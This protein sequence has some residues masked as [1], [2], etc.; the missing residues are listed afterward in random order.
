M[1]ILKCIT[2]Y[3]CQVLGEEGQGQTPVNHVIRE[4]GRTEGSS[5]CSS[6]VAR[7][8]EEYC[9]G[10]STSNRWS[11]DMRFLLLLARWVHRAGKEEDGGW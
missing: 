4:L 5:H 2:W 7:R 8:E 1:L 9:R 11:D 6:A 10:D 3:R